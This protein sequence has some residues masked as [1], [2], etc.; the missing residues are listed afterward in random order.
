MSTG[1]KIGKKRFATIGKGINVVVLRPDGTEASGLW[2]AVHAWDVQN[3]LWKAQG[4]KNNVE[5]AVLQE[6]R[7]YLVE[8][9]E[10][11]EP[12]PEENRAEPKGHEAGMMFLPPGY[13]FAFAN[14]PPYLVDLDSGDDPW[15]PGTLGL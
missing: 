4:W 8:V 12:P 11:G 1:T 14:S 15:P 13:H 5:K 7:K 9:Y 6:N 10:H 3:G 2:F